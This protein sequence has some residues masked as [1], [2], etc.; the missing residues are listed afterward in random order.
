MATLAESFLADLEDLSD[1]EEDDEQQQEQEEDQEVGLGQGAPGVM[2]PCAFGTSS[3]MAVAAAWQ[4]P[5]CAMLPACALQMLGDD[6]DNL[7]YDDLEAVAH[8]ASSERYKSITVAV[9]QALE[10]GDAG[11]ATAWAGPSEED[12]TY[13]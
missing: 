5:L 6:L 9:R 1:V 12:P 8:L 3:C 4:A 11:G 7:N 13:K 2:L 10:E